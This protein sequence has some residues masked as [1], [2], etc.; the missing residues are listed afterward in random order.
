MPQKARKPRKRTTGVKPRTSSPS[1][2]F[3]SPAWERVYLMSLELE[4]CAAQAPPSSRKRSENGFDLVDAAR[5]LARL[6]HNHHSETNPEGRTVVQAREDW[7]KIGGIGAD[8][9]NM[10]E[11]GTDHA[12]TRAIAHELC[13][14]ACDYL[15]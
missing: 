14:L 13:Y 5:E 6:A 12:D 1:K 15:F 10:A 11:E 7:V 2:G 9:G 4:A 3:A 8:L